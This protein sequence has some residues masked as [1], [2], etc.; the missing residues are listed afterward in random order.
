M[1]SSQDRGINFIASHETIFESLR[2][3]I[4][5][6][7]FLSRTWTTTA[8]QYSQTGRTIWLG[9]TSPWIR[10][11]D[12]QGTLLS[13]PRF[14]LTNWSSQ[15]QTDLY[16]PEHNTHRSHLQLQKMTAAINPRKVNFGSW[17]HRHCPRNALI[18]RKMKS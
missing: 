6:R 17:V 10:R 18:K 15:N 5:P 3:E 9:A 1:L 11:C 13:L 7:K 8:A 4:I 16:T 2:E 14:F 12:P